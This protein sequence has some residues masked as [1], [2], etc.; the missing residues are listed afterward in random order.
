MKINVNS[1]LEKSFAFLLV[2]TMQTVYMKLYNSN[3][4]LLL[5]VLLVFV[6]L[7]M[8]YKSKIHINPRLFLWLGVSILLFIFL[9]I[10]HIVFEN[11]NINYSATFLIAVSCIVL[12]TICIV[13]FSGGIKVVN[14]FFINIANAICFVTYITLFLYVFGQV[15]HIIKPTSTNVLISWGGVKTTTTYFYLLFTAQGSAYHSF[16]NGRFTGIYVEA[17]MCA[18]MLCVALIITLYVNQSKLNIFRT[19]IIGFGIYVTA[20]TTGYIVALL[21]LGGYIF[22]QKPKSKKLKLLKYV[23]CLA[24][25]S[26]IIYLIINIYQ[27]KLVAD[28]RSVAVR[29]SNM[30][31]AIANFSKSPLYGYGFKSDTSGVTSGN[32][33]VFSQVVQDGGILFLCW[34]FVPMVMSFIK[35][36]KKKCWKWM[37]AEIL[38]FILLYVTSVT[39][40]SFSIAMVAVFLALAGM[41]FNGTIK[42]KSNDAFTTKNKLLAV[43]Y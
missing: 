35:F 30:S 38:Y 18:F 9:L 22:L 3:L 36:I 20:S 8:I 29:S 32:T 5:S 25:L 26:V 1:F 4:D 19:A 11:S 42:N 43:R 28:V 6:G 14:R 10:C 31:E 16:S 7:L 21:A 40:T 17:P 13:Y 39:Y 33:S 41:R 37:F 27:N 24:A 34:Y 12:F 15:L 23:F 2:I